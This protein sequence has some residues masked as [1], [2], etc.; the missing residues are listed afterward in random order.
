MIHQLNS[1]ENYQRNLWKWDEWKYTE[2]WDNCTLSDVDG[3]GAHLSERKSH[4]IIVEMKHWDGN[5]QRPELN[6]SSGQIRALRQLG[7]VVPRFL[8]IFGFGDTST[9]KVYD[10]E[11]VYQGKDYKPSIDFKQM[12]DLWWESANTDTPVH[13][14]LQST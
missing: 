5:S 11:V 7:I 9:Q 4:F 12:L 2:N 1:E 3:F 13:E 14:L 10:Y 8:V 6:K